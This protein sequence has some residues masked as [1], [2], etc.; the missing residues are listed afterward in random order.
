[1]GSLKIKAIST[2]N[3]GSTLTLNRFERPPPNSMSFTLDFHGPGS[4]VAQLS[5]HGGASI[6]EAKRTPESRALTPE[7]PARAH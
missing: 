1:M 4:S 7:G 6:L 2:A 5:T 3:G